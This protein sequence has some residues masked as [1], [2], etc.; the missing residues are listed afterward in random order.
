V[1]QPDRISRHV[2]DFAA[3][4]PDVLVVVAYG[5]ILSRQ[6]LAVPRRDVVNVHA[7]LL[8]RWRGAAPIQRAL[9]AGDAQTGVSIMRVVHELDAGPVFLTRSTPITAA[10]TGGTLHDR[11]AALGADALV[12]AWPGIVSGDLVPVAQDEAGACYA[13]RIEKAE[14]RVDW[15]VPAEEIVRRIRAFNPWPVCETRLGDERIRLWCAEVRSSESPA[16]PPPPPGQVLRAAGEGVDVA[17]APG[18]VR[19]TELQA[20]G[21]RRLP[22]RDFLNAIALDGARFT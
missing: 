10:D 21:R 1:R 13:R 5:Q 14:A 17:A 15:A 4:R 16:A 22:A 9:E 18:I 6:V 11:L 7:S 20:Q 12:A 19:V 8:P 2:D 3:L